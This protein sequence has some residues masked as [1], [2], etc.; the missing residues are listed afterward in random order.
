M[1][2]CL[3][4]ARVMHYR[5]SPGEHHFR[6]GVYLFYLDLDELDKITNRLHWLS[7]NRFNLFNFRDSDHLQLPADAPDT[8]KN[9]RQHLIDYLEQQGIT[10]SIGS[11]RI[12][13]N[14][15]T[16]GYQFNPVSFYF[17]FDTN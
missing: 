6:Y 5:L 1:N 17:C 11:I 12:L 10:T 14:C 4:K 3:Y 2:S 15:C 9:I 8:T 7:R 13:T 16:L